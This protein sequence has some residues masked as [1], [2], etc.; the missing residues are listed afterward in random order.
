MI[1]RHGAPNKKCAGCRLTTVI[2]ILLYSTA[3]ALCII[4]TYLKDRFLTV[5]LMVQICNNKINSN[6]FQLCIH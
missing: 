3:I 2:A 6:A 5:Y 1:L 4:T